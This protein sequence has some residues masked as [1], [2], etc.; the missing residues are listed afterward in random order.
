MIKTEY[1]IWRRQMRVEAKQMVVASGNKYDKNIL[2]VIVP[3]LLP[4]ETLDINRYAIGIFTDPSEARYTYDIILDE[5][6]EPIHER[7]GNDWE[8]VGIPVKL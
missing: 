6:N 3:C 8:Y 5:N 1:K 4:L 7:K 2:T